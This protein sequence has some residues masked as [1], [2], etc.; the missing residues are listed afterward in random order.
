MEIKIIT[1]NAISETWNDKSD[2]FS[3]I[4]TIYICIYVNIY[5]TRKK[6]TGTIWRVDKMG[7]RGQ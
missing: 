5:M 6:N 4:Y 3:H 1:L 7:G 2:M